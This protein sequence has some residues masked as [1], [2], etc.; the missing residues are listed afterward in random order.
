MPHILIV[1][2]ENANAWALSESLQDEGYLT[3][4]VACAEKALERMDESEFDLVITDVRLPEMNGLKLVRRILSGARPIPV[5]VVT[6]YG[7]RELSDELSAIGVH[8]LFPKPFRVD[9]LRR[10]VRDALAGPGEVAG[11]DTAGVVSEGSRP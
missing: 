9:Q 11:E 3:T 7:S 10:S 5:I 2:D 1:E 8:A 4:H 6:A